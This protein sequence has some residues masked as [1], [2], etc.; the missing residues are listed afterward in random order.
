VERKDERKLAMKIT[1][2]A[3]LISGT[4]QAAPF[5]DTI[6]LRTIWTPTYCITDLQGRR[7]T[8][9]ITYRSLFGGRWQLNGTRRLYNNRT[10][11]TFSGTVSDMSING[12]FTRADFEWTA[13]GYK[14]CIYES[15][16]E[17]LATDFTV[18]IA[19]GIV[20]GTATFLPE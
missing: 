20:S 15:E 1:L 12:T 10:E 17:D 3:I 8:W 19:N 9:G 18:T 7:S 11:E 2:I 14:A 13:D 4:I 16:D 6:P 5:S